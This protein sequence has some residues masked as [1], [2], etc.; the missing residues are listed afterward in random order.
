MAFMLVPGPDATPAM[1]TCMIPFE[2]STENLRI[3]AV[4]TGTPAGCSRGPRPSSG[5]AGQPPPALR[6]LNR[7]LGR[8]KQGILQKRSHNP[9]RTT[10]K[11]APVVGPTPHICLGPVR[12]AKEEAPFQLRSRQRLHEAA[13]RRGLDIGA[14]VIWHK[15]TDRPKTGQTSPKQRTVTRLTAVA[16]E[17]QRYSPAAGPQARSL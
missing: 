3:A 17:A 8:Y 12:A 4:D 7:R 6:R 15:R 14:K 2:P 13:M 10:W 9:R 11:A 16:K 1:E 5:V